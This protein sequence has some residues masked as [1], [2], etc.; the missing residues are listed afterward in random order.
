MTGARRTAKSRERRGTDAIPSHRLGSVVH[1]VRLSGFGSPS[2]FVQRRS[3][4]GVPCTHIA[5]GLAFRPDAMHECIAR[6]HRKRWPDSRCRTPRRSS[7]PLVPRAPPRCPSNGYD[8][9]SK[10]LDRIRAKDRT[11]QPRNP[12][13]SANADRLAYVACQG[14]LSQRCAPAPALAGR[15]QGS[16]RR[17]TAPVR[18]VA[19]RVRSASLHVSA[20]R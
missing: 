16:V 10:D 6:V 7:G 8:R 19:R 3:H 5:V 17:L 12:Y 14:W 15:G 1:A 13:V 11:P 20:P 9:W 2:N 4:V 18:S